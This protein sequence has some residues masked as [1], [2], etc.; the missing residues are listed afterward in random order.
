MWQISGGTGL[1]GPIP[2]Q[3]DHPA[4]VVL[5]GKRVPYHS[6]QLKNPMSREAE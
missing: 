2:V 3:S 1:L 4:H 6:P 5:Q